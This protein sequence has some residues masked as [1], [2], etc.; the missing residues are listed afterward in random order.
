MNSHYQFAV[1]ALLAKFYHMPKQS[2]ENPHLPK[3]KPV[4]VT[5]VKDG[6]LSKKTYSFEEALSEGILDAHAY[7]LLDN[8]MPQ[9]RA[10]GGVSCPHCGYAQRD[11]ERT[12]RLGCPQCVGHFQELLMPLIERMHKGTH[13]KGK[14][15]ECQIETITLSNDLKELKRQLDAAIE[16]ERYEDA[17]RLRDELSL[18]E[19]K[20]EAARRRE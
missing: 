17:A 12:G 18:T 3:P 1:I 15:P 11:F 10:G 2:G 6:Q 4:H 20:L 5:L 9:Q 8:G 7:A 14:V 13:H 19:Q 16:Q